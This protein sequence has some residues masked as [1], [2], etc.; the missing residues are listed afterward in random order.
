MLGAVRA[1][2]IDEHLVDRALPLEP[3]NEHGHDPGVRTGDGLRVQLFD[4]H[5]LGE[6]IVLHGN[7]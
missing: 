3:H 6:E 4:E 7:G 1:M 5:T 2:M